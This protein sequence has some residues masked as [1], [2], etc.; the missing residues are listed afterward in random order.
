MRKAYRILN[1]VIAAEVVVQAAFIA[2]AV[3]GVSKYIKDSGSVTQKQID[4][5]KTLFTGEYGFAVHAINGYMVIPLVGLALLVVAFFAKLPGGVRWAA[6]LFVLILVQALVLP[7][8]AADAPSVGLLHGANAMAILALSI[9]GAKRA[10]TAPEPVV[11]PA[12]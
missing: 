5:N 11:A 12:A 10:G 2:W 7:A 4:G 6:I 8:L 1:Y 9:I 3:F